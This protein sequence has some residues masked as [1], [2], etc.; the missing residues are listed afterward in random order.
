MFV[1]SSPRGQHCRYAR[2]TLRLYEQDGEKQLIREYLL[3]LGGH[4]HLLE[5]L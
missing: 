2:M 4:Q 5:L 1:R 3:G